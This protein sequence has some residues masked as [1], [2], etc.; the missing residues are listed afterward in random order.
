ME[1]KRWIRLMESDSLQLTDEEIA[2]GWHFC[3]DWDWL[4]VGPSMPMEWDRCT[5][6]GDKKGLYADPQAGQ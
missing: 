1:H 2:Q 6:H 3:G 4:L 5:C